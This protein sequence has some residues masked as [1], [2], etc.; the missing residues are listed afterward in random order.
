MNKSPIKDVISLKSLIDVAVLP[1]IE[2]KGHLNFIPK[3]KY[4]TVIS[5]T[6]KAGGILA[7]SENQKELS[8]KNLRIQ[9]SILQEAFENTTENSWKY[10]KLALQTFRHHILLTGNL[11]GNKGFAIGESEGIS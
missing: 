5:K 6:G 9:L 2:N 7:I 10:T 1:L 3:Q 11:P 4:F 8:L